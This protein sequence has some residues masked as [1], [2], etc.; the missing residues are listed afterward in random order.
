MSAISLAKYV[1]ACGL[2]ILY[3]GVSRLFSKVKGSNT[4]VIAFANSKPR[5]CASFPTVSMSFN[6]AAFALG[7]VQS[8]FTSLFLM[9][10][11][12]AH[13]LNIS[14]ST[15]TMATREEFRLS[16]CIKHCA[17]YLLFA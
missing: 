4:K 9:P 10:S 1:L 14:G 2:F 16:P 3:V 8:C 11:F 15:Q 17:T 5:N 12:I 6:I 13:A 7:S